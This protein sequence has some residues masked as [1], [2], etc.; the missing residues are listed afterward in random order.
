M[1]N[2]VKTIVRVQRFLAF[3]VVYSLSAR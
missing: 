2:N 3:M 1:V